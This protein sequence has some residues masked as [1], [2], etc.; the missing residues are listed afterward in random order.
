MS[1]W[2]APSLFSSED[3]EVVG[4]FIARIEEARL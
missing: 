1:I 4:P 3:H 2:A